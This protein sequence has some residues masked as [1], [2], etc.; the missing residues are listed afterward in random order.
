M[1]DGEL[2]EE[3]DMLY[4]QKLADTLKIIADDPEAFYDPSSQ[5]AQDIVAD[6]AEYGEE[7]YNLCDDIWPYNLILL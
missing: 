5:L 3:G 6:I 2:L 7:K 4:N 1:R